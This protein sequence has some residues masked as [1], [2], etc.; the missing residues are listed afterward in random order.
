MV[1][2]SGDVV[3]VWVGDHSTEQEKLLAYK[4]AEVMDSMAEIL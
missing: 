4:M 3:Y 1:L 2:D